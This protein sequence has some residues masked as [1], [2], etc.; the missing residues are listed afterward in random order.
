MNSRGKFELSLVSGFAGIQIDLS[1]LA[2]DLITFTGQGFN[3]FTLS[4]PFTTGSSIMPQ[5]ENPDVLEL[6]R[7][8]AAGFSGYISSLYN[9]LTGLRSGYSR[10]LQETKGYL[11]RA[12][13]D[14]ENTLGVLVPLIDG[15]GVNEE[16][17]LSA[18]TE[19][20]LATDRVFG[21]VN[22]GEP[23]RSAYRKVKETL[24]AKESGSS[25]SE[26]KVRKALSSRNHEGGPGHLNL[27]EAKNV[28]EEDRAKWEKR[29]DTFQGKLE[30]LGTTENT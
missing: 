25:V 3:Y 1:R 8:R 9:L 28:L 22:E 6:V 17:L 20:V 7:G 26:D 13:D 21:L 23:F 14:T 30:K 16:E 18:F 27:E 24:E 10:D 5:K 12:I 2:E 11:M 4:E 15:L 19:E 29:R